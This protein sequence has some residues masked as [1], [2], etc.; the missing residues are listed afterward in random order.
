MAGECPPDLAKSGLTPWSPEHTNPDIN[1]YQLPRKTMINTP[2][3]TEVILV[4][5][6]TAKRVFSQ[7]IHGEFT[8]RTEG[9]LK[10]R[11]DFVELI[12]LQI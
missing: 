1:D 4:E 11:K 2:Q 3:G 7:P 6:Y 5:K 8:V 9:L 10:P 12:L